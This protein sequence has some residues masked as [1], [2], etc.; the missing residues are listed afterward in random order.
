MTT[1][2]GSSAKA[3]PLKH[4]ASAKWMSTLVD[5]NMESTISAVVILVRSLSHLI[6]NNE[7]VLMFA[8]LQR[9]LTS[10]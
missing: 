2:S 4:I 1:F 7:S 6:R 9:Y 8:F 10:K 5:C 3:K